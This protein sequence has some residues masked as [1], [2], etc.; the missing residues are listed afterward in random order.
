MPIP[1]LYG[2][3]GIRN[4]LAGALAAGRLPQALLFEGPPGVGKQ[5]LA[6]W[7]AQAILCEAG[8]GN[9]EGCGACRAC[10]LVLNLSHPDVHWFVPVEPPKKAADPDKL[11]DLVA[12]ALAEEMAAR[13]EG[14]LYEPPSGLAG[15]GIAS[16]R[17][18]LRRL[19]LTPA[20]GGRKVFIIGDAE[21]LVPQPGAEAAANALLKALEE[22][23]QDTVFVLTTAQP[24]ALLTTILSRVVRVR[25]AGNSDSVLA[26]FARTELGLKSEPEIVQRV[27]AADGCIGRLLAPEQGGPASGE[28]EITGRFLGAAEGGSARRYAFALGQQPFQ[29]RGA[30]TDMLDGLLERLRHEARNGADLDKVVEAIARVLDAR[31]LAQGNVNPQL[32]AA[33]LA[34]DLAEHA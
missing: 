19:A 34:D 17:L 5:R 1:P 23:P 27:A 9:G 14:P 12:D 8:P 25:V 18:L 21:R 29:A 7:L 30:F 31:R 11:V 20:M 3:E 10:K 4:R 22:P 28:S 16:V 6:L 15:H 26:A 32:I 33:V 24:D 2:H 13:R